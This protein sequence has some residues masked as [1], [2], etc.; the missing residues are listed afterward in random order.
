MT[1][2][3]YGLARRMWHGL[4][5]VHAVDRDRMVGS[6]GPAGLARVDRRRPPPACEPPGYGAPDTT[7]PPPALVTAC[8]SGSWLAPRGLPT[9][10]S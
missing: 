8:D 9:T 10:R 7:D 2:G 1:A 4:E 3:G 5:P 6:P